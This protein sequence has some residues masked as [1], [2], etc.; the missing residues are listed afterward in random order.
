MTNKRDGQ[1]SAWIHSNVIPM[2]VFMIICTLIPHKSSASTTNTF[3]VLVATGSL[4]VSGP[5]TFNGDSMSVGASTL[6]VSHGW[7]G[8]GT[9]TPLGIVHVVQN[10]PGTHHNIELLMWHRNVES[11]LLFG[12][13][14]FDYWDFYNV[15]DR[16]VALGGVGSLIRGSDSGII[17]GQFNFNYGNSSFI[18]G[19]FN[20]TIDSPTFSAS[21][22]AIVGGGDGLATGDGS[23]IGGGSFNTVDRTGSAV[24]GGEN[25]IAIGT[26]SV[27]VGGLNNF[28]SGHYSTILGGIGNIAAGNYS[29]AGGNFAHAAGRGSFVWADS[30][31][32]EFLSSINDEFKIRAQGGFVLYS[33][34]S[35]PTVIVSSGAIMISTSATGASAM[36]NLFISSSNGNVGLGTKF[37][38]TILDVNGSAQF[39]AGATKSSFTTTGSLALAS[40]AS[41]TGASATFSASGSNVY[42]LT[43]SSGIH[44]L[45]GG[46]TWP[47]GTTSVTAAGGGG[48]V[49]QSTTVYIDTDKSINSDIWNPCFTNSTATL[50]G[51]TSSCVLILASGSWILDSAGYN[52]GLALIVNGALVAGTDASKRSHGQVWACPPG[53][54]YSWPFNIAERVCGLNSSTVTV[55]LA[56][57]AENSAKL[58]GTIGSH[59]ARN[60]T[61]S[62]IEIK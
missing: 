50:T 42:S 13:R 4:T 11:S 25:N 39:G 5:A 9:T 10:N 34:N 37:P 29:L 7:V 47:D 26:G 52:Y 36:P 31:T 59:T 20:H 18:G 15:G 40:G 1:V 44:I 41:I 48:T 27:V 8:I 56:G 17:G 21:G 60:P 22:T 35:S 38:A 55:C 62:I 46:L 33:A 30:Q 6:V 14:Q 28:A 53:G 2:A 23:F 43:S 49:V 45:A 16:S 54:G 32:T 3:D 19:G 57:S 61:L 12:L 51:V 58:A 24:I